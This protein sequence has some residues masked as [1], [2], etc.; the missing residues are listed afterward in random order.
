MKKLK[1][2]QNNWPFPLWI[3]HRGGGNVAPENTMKGFEAG[4]AYGLTGVEFDVKP[5]SYTHLT[6]PTKA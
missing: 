5:V 2:D 1:F 4:Y 6:L 3:A